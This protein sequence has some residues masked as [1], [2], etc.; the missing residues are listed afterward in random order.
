MFKFANEIM[1]HLNDLLVPYWFFLSS[2]R[3]IVQIFHIFIILHD[4][5]FFWVNTFHLN[6]V[7]GK[8]FCSLTGKKLKR[9]IKYIKMR[10]SK[11]Y[12]IRHK[13]TPNP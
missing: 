2:V 6:L 11:S 3:S 13:R 4:L 7:K 1:C 8:Q 5:P 10:Y 12:L 9:N